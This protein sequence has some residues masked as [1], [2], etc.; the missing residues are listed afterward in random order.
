MGQE[1]GVACL[2]LQATKG[3][4][5]AV[6]QVGRTQ[7]SPP[8]LVFLLS[9]SPGIMPSNPTQFPSYREPRADQVCGQ[10]AVSWVCSLA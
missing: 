9:Q 8:N 3:A 6:L 1:A 5:G 7:R 4:S 10:A 2:Q